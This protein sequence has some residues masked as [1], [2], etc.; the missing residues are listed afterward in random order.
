[1]IKQFVKRGFPQVWMTQN[2]EIVF[3]YIIEQYSKY[4]RIHTFN[5][6]ERELNCPPQDIEKI[7]SKFERIGLIY[8]EKNA[9]RTNIILSLGLQK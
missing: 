5:E 4:D 3:N 6:I 2:Q 9:E 1:M 7:L 8:K